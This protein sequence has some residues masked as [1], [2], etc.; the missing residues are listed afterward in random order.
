MQVERITGPVV[1]QAEI[2]LLVVERLARR[3]GVVSIEEARAIREARKTVRLADAAD[4]TVGCAVSLFRRDG[5]R[6][7]QFGKRLR[8]LQEDLGRIEDDP[9]P[10]PDGPGAAQKRAA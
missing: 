4:A 6:G 2:V 10:T 8:A 7:Q 5:V 3:D 9:D 1:E